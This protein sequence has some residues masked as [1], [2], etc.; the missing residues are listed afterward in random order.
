[1]ASE[2][3]IELSSFVVLYT[4]EACS[5]VLRAIRYSLP[6]YSRYTLNISSTHKKTKVFVPN[7]SIKCKLQMKLIDLPISMAFKVAI[8]NR[9]LTICFFYIR[10][11]NA[12]TSSLLLILFVAN[13][14][15]SFVF[16]DTG[17]HLFCSKFLFLGSVVLVIHS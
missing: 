7:V 2:S 13:P 15:Q 3:V 17:G 11:V 16:I 8:F 14:L 1:M 6:L 5:S 10:F 4:Y 12:S 9:Y